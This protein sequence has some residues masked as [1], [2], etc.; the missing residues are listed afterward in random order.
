MQWT[1]ITAQGD[2]WDVLALDIYGSEKL[3]H[4]LMD[5][6]PDYLKYIY[7]PAGITLTIP[8]TPET[9]SVLPVPPWLE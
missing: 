1:Y 3:A 7:F 9:A 6:N 5:A 2:T 4:I 8:D